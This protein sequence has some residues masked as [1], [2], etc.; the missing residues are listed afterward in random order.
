MLDSLIFKFEIEMQKKCCLGEDDSYN[1]YVILWLAFFCNN[2][3]TLKYFFP[4]ASENVSTSLFL[5]SVSVSL[6]KVWKLLLTTPFHY[7]QQPSGRCKVL[8]KTVV[9]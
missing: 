8:I 7:S 1:Y 6:W 3:K 4:S 9:F 5:T 2:G